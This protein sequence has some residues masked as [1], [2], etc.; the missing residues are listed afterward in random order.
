M[1]GWTVTEK[2]EGARSQ[3]DDYPL[4]PGDFIVEEDGT[5]P[6]AEA[7]TFFK[8]GP[9]LGVGGFRLTDEQRATLVEDEKWVVI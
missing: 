5:D 7:G 8:V 2:I 1:K 3:Y 9:G 4:L 6:D